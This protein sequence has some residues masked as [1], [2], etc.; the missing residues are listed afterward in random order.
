MRRNIIH[1]ILLF[2]IVLTS[3]NDWLE[4]EPEQSISE[5]LAFSTPETAM[6]VVIGAY[7]ALY[8]RGYYGRDFIAAPELLADNLKVTVANTGRLNTHST[9]D[10]RSHVGDAAMWTAAYTLINRANLVLANISSVSG[11][12]D[13][14]K[15]QI[16]GEMLFLRALTYFDLLRSYSRNPGYQVDGFD[17]GVP[18]LLTPFD[19]LDDDAF[20]S[21]ETT[22]V[23]YDQVKADFNES[24]TLMDNSNGPFFGSQVAAKALLSRVHL[25]LG[26]WQDA[27]DMA[28]EAITESG[29]TL[30]DGDTYESIFSSDSEAIFSVRITANESVDGNNNSLAVLYTRDENGAGYG[31][32]VLRENFKDQFESGDKREALTIDADH[33]GEAVTYT[34]KFYSYGGQIGVD[35]VPVIRLSELYL[36]RAEA[37]AE[38]GNTSSAQDDLNAIRSRAGLGDITSTGATL[39]QDILDERRV[40]LAFEGH[41]FFDLKR[42]GLDIPKGNSVD[43]CI[44]CTILYEDYRVVAAIDQ[45]EL[46]VNSNLVN[47]PGYSD[48]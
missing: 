20:P 4:T 8:D 42:R 29:L 14:E 26:E 3:C 21:R 40:E 31:D 48:N 17:L 39:I 28:T 44:T 22:G 18:L 41:R 25:Y 27:V 32:A 16:R 23:V 10:E 13:E 45:G 12:S 19:G 35:N 38:L 1:I 11:M 47:N 46:D 24:I 6:A 5:D 9:N 36:N 15:E 43:D 30:E 34:L 33:D 7:T 2:C 37:N